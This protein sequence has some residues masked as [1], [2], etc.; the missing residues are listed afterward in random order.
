MA[1]AQPTH[2]VYADET[3]HNQGRYRGV[4]ASSLSIVD[5][6]PATFELE[7]ILQQSSVG[8]F[9]WSELR[10]ARTRFVA[11]AMPTFC[12]GSGH[13]RNSAY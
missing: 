13:G 4:A 11:L 2:I 3:T 12:S 10:T 7:V 6:R 5:A 9:K 8:E 1:T